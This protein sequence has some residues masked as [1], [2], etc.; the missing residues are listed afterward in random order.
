MPA[1]FEDWLQMNPAAPAA[2]PLADN[3]PTI[4]GLL[5]VDGCVMM[6]VLRMLLVL[7][8][9]LNAIASRPDPA[10][11]HRVGDIVEIAPSALNVKLIYGPKAS[12]S[13]TT[14]RIIVRN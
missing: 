3:P 10:R 5:K 2:Q 12:R 1:R 6:D 11:V 4:S 13:T 7:S 9:I 14:S 8:V